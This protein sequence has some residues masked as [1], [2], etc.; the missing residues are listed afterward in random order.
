MAGTGDMVGWACCSCRQ[1]RGR[2]TVAAPQAVHLCIPGTST[3]WHTG[4]GAGRLPQEKKNT[5]HPEAPRGECAA[6][7]DFLGSL[8]NID[9]AAAARLQQQGVQQAQQAQRAWQAQQAA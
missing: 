6:E 8:G 2:T 1:A 9:E 7:D 5:P 4:R 3:S